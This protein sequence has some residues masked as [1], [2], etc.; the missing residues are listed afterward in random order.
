MLEGFIAEH[1][2]IKHEVGL[3]KQLVEKSGVMR[4]G[5]WEGC[6]RGLWAGGR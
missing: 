6:G 5:E 4:D 3:L 2:A 1:D